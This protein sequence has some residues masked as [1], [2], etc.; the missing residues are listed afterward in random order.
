VWQPS[1]WPEGRP[2]ATHHPA[3][4][5]TQEVAERTAVKKEKD[6][7]ANINTCIAA[8]KKLQEAHQELLSDDGIKNQIAALKNHY[9]SQISD[10]KALDFLLWSAG[11]K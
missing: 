1:S 9:N 2:S 11:G 3:G 6:F 5:N 7:D 10:E 4:I 8:Y